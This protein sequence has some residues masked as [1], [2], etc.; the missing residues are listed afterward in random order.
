MNSKKLTIIFSVLLGFM[1]G[2]F[3]MM[4]LMGFTLSKF[5]EDTVTF[6][7]DSEWFSECI[8]HEYGDFVLIWGTM[9]CE[10]MGL[11]KMRLQDKK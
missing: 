3:A 6:Q 7:T 8:G 9:D 2:S 5:N 10:D 1:L 4:M 11:D